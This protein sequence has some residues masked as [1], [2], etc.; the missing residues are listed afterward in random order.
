MWP[1]AGRPRLR[2]LRGRHVRRA[3]RA[4]GCAVETR[5]DRPAR[6]RAAPHARQVRGAHRPRRPRAARRRRR[7]LRALPVPDR[8]PWRPRPRRARTASPTCSP[9]TARTCATWTAGRCAGPPPPALSRAAGADRREPAPG[10]RAARGRAARCRRSTWSTWAS[11]SSASRPATGPPARARLGLAPDGPLVL[12]VGRPDGAQEPARPAAGLRARAARAARTRGSR[13]WATARWRR[14]V[15]A[16]ARRLG[17]R[18]RGDAPGRRPARR[19]RGLGRRLRPAGHGQPGGAARRGGARGPGGRAAGGGDRGRR[20]GRGGAGPGAGRL[21]DPA[22][23][24][25]DRDG[26]PAAVLDDPP[27]R[28]GVPAR[29]RAPR[30]RRGRPAGSPR[31]CEGAVAAHR[32]ASAR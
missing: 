18:R 23:P 17:A 12:A 16:G 28:R 25:R 8:A 30:A 7:H 21:V 4:G 13:W 27:A 6:R 2:R 10:R 11:T 31:S 22:R 1:G 15:D 9:P 3:A 26:D 14:A 5:G 19:R 20:G 29:R 32:E 24:R